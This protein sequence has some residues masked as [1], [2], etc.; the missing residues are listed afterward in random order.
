MPP[1]EN[2]IVSSDCERRHAPCSGPTRAREKIPCRPLEDASFLTSCQRQPFSRRSS[3]GYFPHRRPHQ[4][5]F[6]KI[7]FNPSSLVIANKGVPTSTFSFSGFSPSFNLADNSYPFTSAPIASGKIRGLTVFLSQGILKADFA[8]SVEYSAGNAVEVALTTT[9]AQPSALPE[10]GL[11]LCIALRSLRQTRAHDC[12]SV[13]SHLIGL[14]HQVT[15]LEN[16]FPAIQSSQRED[17]LFATK[18]VLDSPR[19][20]TAEVSRRCCAS[21]SSE[22]LILSVPHPSAAPRH[23]GR[24]KAEDPIRFNGL[25]IGWWRIRDSNPGP[26]DYDSVALTD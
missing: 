14:R 8:S 2:R 17:D 3:A 6:D 26:A 15:C 10:P 22:T 7:Y 4:R 20:S 19:H 18:D 11:A 25:G 23:N 1:Q 13:S 9:A 24:R 5:N 16:R 12:G 21:R